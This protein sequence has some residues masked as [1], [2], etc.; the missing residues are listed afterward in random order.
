MNGWDVTGRYSRDGDV[1]E[2]TF[3]SWR[4]DAARALSAAGLRRRKT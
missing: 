3:R 2:T 1:N 4:D